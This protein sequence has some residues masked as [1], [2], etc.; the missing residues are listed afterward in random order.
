[1][2]VEATMM[3]FAAT[4]L[5]IAYGVI[6][7]FSGIFINL[8]VGVTKDDLSKYWILKLI[9]VVSYLPYQLIFIWMIPLKAELN[10]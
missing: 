4:M 7:K 6:G 2:K 1:M 8:F 3:A 10:E 9:N 5:N